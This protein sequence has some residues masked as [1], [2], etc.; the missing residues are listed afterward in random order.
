[1]NPTPGLFSDNTLFGGDFAKELFAK[2]TSP[3]TPSR[4]LY[5]FHGL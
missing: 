3:R 2:K 4:T 1:M 5:I